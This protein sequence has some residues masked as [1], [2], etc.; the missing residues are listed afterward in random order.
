MLSALKN[1][2]LVAHYIQTLKKN[3]DKTRAIFDENGIKHIRVNEKQ[4]VLSI[5][6]AFQT[7]QYAKKTGA[8]MIAIMSVSSEEYHYFAQQDKE[9]L[10]TNES[11]IP[12]LCACNLVKE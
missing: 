1:I 3:L 2:Y 8:D 4:T 7:M 6:F 5:G 9:N 11:G 10:L 12:V